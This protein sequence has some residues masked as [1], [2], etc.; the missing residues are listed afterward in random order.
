MMSAHVRHFK[1]THVLQDL[2][3][4][5]VNKSSICA[6]FSDYAPKEKITILINTEHSHHDRTSP[7]ILYTFASHVYQVQIIYTYKPF[8]VYFYSLV[9]ILP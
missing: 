5:H 3:K 6:L 8:L 7:C 1:I 4:V 2:T 9:G